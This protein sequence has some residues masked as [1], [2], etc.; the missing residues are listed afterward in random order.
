[1]N[2]QSIERFVGQLIHQDSVF[3]AKRENII[4]ISNMLF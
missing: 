4:G 1:M 2:L 3:V